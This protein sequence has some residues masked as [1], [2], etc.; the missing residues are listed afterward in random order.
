MNDK[1]FNFSE[2]SNLLDYT[3]DSTTTTKKLNKSIESF[4]SEDLCMIA[5]T[6]LENSFY[7]EKDD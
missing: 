4:N 7:L 5:S 6:L 2:L 1:S 3:I